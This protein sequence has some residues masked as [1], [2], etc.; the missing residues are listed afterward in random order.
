MCSSD[1]PSALPRLEDPD[2]Q[3][4]AELRAEAMRSA[5]PSC[6]KPI[7]EHTPEEVRACA[8]KQRDIRL[9]DV[10]CPICN[11]LVLE[12]SQS[13]STFCSA[14]SRAAEHENAI[15]AIFAVKSTRS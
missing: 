11:K 7:G 5:C 13:E 9:K 4:R 12:H 2:P 15:E 14:K 8:D 3:K 6:N 10:R 1:L